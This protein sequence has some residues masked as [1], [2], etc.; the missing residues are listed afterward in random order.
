MTYCGSVVGLSSNCDSKERNI[1]FLPTRKPHSWTG[2]GIQGSG[3]FSGD[4]NAIG[5]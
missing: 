5:K 2:Q 1:P 4:S 3:R